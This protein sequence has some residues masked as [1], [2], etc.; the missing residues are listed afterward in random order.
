MKVDS[1]LLSE[2]EFKTMLSIKEENPVREMI[3]DKLAF[4]GAQNFWMTIKA[5]IEGGMWV[6]VRRHE[7]IPSKISELDLIYNMARFGYKEHGRTI[8]PGIDYSIELTV[9]AMLALGQARLIEATAV[10]LAK[11]NSN[12]NVLFFLA[13]KFHLLD[14]LLPVLRALVIVLPKDKTRINQLIEAIEK[15]NIK[16][17][18]DLNTNSI[19][20]KIR[21]Y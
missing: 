21:L 17:T 13:R 3:G 6:R 14:V 2:S 15:M 19:E 11:Q 8:R 20:E 12:Y 16:T 18:I 5:A 1:L 4:F 7:T 9:A 10:I